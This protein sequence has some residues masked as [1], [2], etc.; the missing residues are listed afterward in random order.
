MLAPLGFLPLLA[1]RT[2]AAALPGLAMN[3]LSVDPILINHRSQ[4]QSFVLPFLMLAAVDGYFGVRQRAAQSRLPGIALGAAVCLALILTAR[5]FNDFSIRNWRPGED[6]RAAHRLMSRVPRDAPVSA[7]ERLVPHL[8]MR[9]NIFVFPRGLGISAHVI[10]RAD[11]L[12]R[13]PAPGY[14]ERERAGGWVLLGRQG[15]N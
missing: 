11:V 8:V 3:L 13:V 14:A 1:P 2:L 7:N 4:Y 9:E 6:Q 5:T 12:A 10:E 15:H